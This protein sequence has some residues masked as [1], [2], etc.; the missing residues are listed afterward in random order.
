M[1][2]KENYKEL[3]CIGER[4]DRVVNKLIEKNNAGE[5]YYVEFNGNML[6][7]DT[8]TVEPS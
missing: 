2:T 4:L 3:D 1:N 5:K 6:Y 8:V 7:S